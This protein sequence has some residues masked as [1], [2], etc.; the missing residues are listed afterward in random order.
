MLLAL[1]TQVRLLE[2]APSTEIGMGGLLALLVIDRVLSF[3]RAQRTKSSNASG[4][5]P[6]DFWKSEIRAGVLDGFN[7]V[8]KPILESEVK[9]LDQL[10]GLQRESNGLLKELLGYA[11]RQGR[12]HGER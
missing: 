4:E 9:Q 3:V 7:L 12:H 1:P 10:L 11:E 2:M 5:K 8:M 6:V